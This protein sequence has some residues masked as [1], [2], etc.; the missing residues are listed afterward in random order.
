MRSSGLPAHLAAC[1]C[2]SLVRR[3]HWPGRECVQPGRGETGMLQCISL[4]IVFLMSFGL[5]CGRKGKSGQDAGPGMERG[6]ASLMPP[7]QPPSEQVKPP[8]PIEA[9]SAAAEQPGVAAEPVSLQ[10]GFGVCARSACPLDFA[11]S[12]PMVEADTL[13][14]AVIPK[15]VLDP[16]Q[17][18]RFTWQSA[19]V[20]RFTPDPD[21]LA[22]G[23]KIAVTISKATPLAGA[24]LGLAEPWR[25]DFTVPFFRVGGKVAPR[26]DH[27]RAGLCLRRAR[28]ARPRVP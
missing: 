21:A 7:E 26:P 25:R 3:L 23:H 28:R 22:W 6:V 27:S 24:A 10:V 5:A 9:K 14:T 8:A 13:A 12:L 15:V 16:P 11:F 4:A 18:G 19:T 1:W 20:L 17:K 2:H